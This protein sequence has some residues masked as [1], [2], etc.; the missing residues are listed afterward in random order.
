MY[1]NLAGN[2]W[3][4]AMENGRKQASCSDTDGRAKT[5]AP[6]TMML[7]TGASHGWRVFLRAKVI[8]FTPAVQRCIFIGRAVRWAF[9]TLHIASRSFIE[10]RSTSCKM[11][12]VEF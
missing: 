1:E 3:L 10:P 9:G 12:R 4:T 7:L 5:T 2:G 8:L 6:S 11:K